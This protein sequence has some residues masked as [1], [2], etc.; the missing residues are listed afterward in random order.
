[1]GNDPAHIPEGL[2]F[3]ALISSQ[4]VECQAE[5]HAARS[6]LG[7][8]APRCLEELGTLLSLLDRLAS[9]AWGCNGD[10]HIVE[11]L[12]G[13]S[14]TLA[15][16][17]L[18]LSDAGYYDEALGLV[19]SLGEIA[20]L[21]SLFSSDK[22]SFADWTAATRRDRI[23][24]F[25]PAA[26][27]QKLETLNAPAPVGADRYSALCELAAHV[28]PETR[29]QAHNPVLMP[30]LGAVF[31]R[32]GYLMVLNELAVPTVFVGLFASS[33]LQV[34]PE[35]KSRFAA[36]GRAVAENIG[37]VNVIAGYPRLTDETLA[38]LHQL[39]QQAPERDRPLIREAIRRLADLGP[40]ISDS[41]GDT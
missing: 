8:K 11:Y 17:A 41:R 36:T 33:L 30:N 4:E 5:T 19:R 40:P 37:G 6:H 15:R 21:L 26:V 13:R 20:N 24:R 1:M 10:P 18:R 38:E 32:V 39:V 23:R 14:T 29:P 9:C 12:T 2:E 25:G 34:P 16:G 35:P 22:T 31:S 7:T 27:R 28:T 3:L